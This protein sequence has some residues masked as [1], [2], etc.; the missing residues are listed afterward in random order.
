ML[1][2][3]GGVL[4]LPIFAAE[5]L[6]DQTNHSRLVAVRVH[7]FKGTPQFVRQLGIELTHAE[8]QLHAESLRAGRLAHTGHVLQA[9]IQEVGPQGVFLHLHTSAFSPTYSPSAWQGLS[10]RRAIPEVPPI[11]CRWPWSIPTRRSSPPDGLHR[12]HIYV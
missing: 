4:P 12:T 6:L 9:E 8:G 5:N 7:R 10:T 11:P 1:F 3:S 2:P